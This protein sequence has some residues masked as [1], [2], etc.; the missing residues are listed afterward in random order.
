MSTVFAVGPTRAMAQSPARLALLGTG[1]V[2][3][4]VLQRLA[5][6]QGTPLGA[7]L[8][9]VH[10]ANSR[11]AIASHSGMAADHIAGRLP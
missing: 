8:S 1:T 11:H 4:A 5:Q 7:R 3:S 9:L 2:G 6:W 10:A